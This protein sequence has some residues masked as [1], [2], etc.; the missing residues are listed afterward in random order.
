MSENKTPAPAAKDATEDANAQATPVASE[1]TAGEPTEAPASQAAEAATK[2]SKPKVHP[3]R[4]AYEL[5]HE[6]YPELFDLKAAKPLQIGIHV[7]LAEDGKLSK[8]KIRRALNS[9]VQQLAYIRS[10]ANGGARHGL[11]GEVG[12]V[13]EE[14]QAHAKARVE[15]IEAKRKA[16]REERRQAQQKKARPG[17]R[18][19]QQGKPADSGKRQ[20]PRG[21]AANKPAQAAPQRGH[22]D[23]DNRSSDTRAQGTKEERMNQKL[24][25]LA[26]RFN[27]G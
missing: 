14:D 22:S 26:E 13:S 20:K 5:L 7:S 23:S 15:D 18:S 17:N 21:G 4:A 27:N 16:K 9:Y 10:V 8:T 24:A 1:P 19:G 6:H 25:S 2:P 11:A 3:N 12:T